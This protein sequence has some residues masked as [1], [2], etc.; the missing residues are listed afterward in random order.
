LEN[1]SRAV[2]KSVYFSEREWRYVDDSRIV[3]NRQR[4]KAG[5]P[6]A[7]WMKFARRR[8]MTGEITQIV[9]PVNIGDTALELARIGNNINQIAHKV[10]M[11]DAAVFEQLV[12]VQGQLRELRALLGRISAEAYGSVEE[13]AW[14]M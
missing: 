10:N 13:S 8:L 12:A 7:G 14:L 6:P 1:R 4:A 11:Q 3:E 9:V 2:E 5:L